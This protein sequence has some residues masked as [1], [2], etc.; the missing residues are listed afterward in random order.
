MTRTMRILTF[1]MLAIVVGTGHAWAA[2]D[3]PSNIKKGTVSNG[4]IE[5]YADEACTMSFDTD[6]AVGATVYVKAT[7]APGYTAIG[8]TFT[9]TKGIGTNLIQ[10]PRRIGI[11]SD[12]AVSAVTGKPD[13]YSFT[14]PED[15]NFTVTVSATFATPAQQLVSYVDG[16]YETK[17]INA[18]VLDETMHVLPAGFYIVPEGV[19][20]LDNQ[21]NISGNVNL[22]LADGCQM[23]ATTISGSESQLTIYAQTG[24]QTGQ[25]VAAAYDCGVAFGQ[26]FVVYN[27]ATGTAASAIVSGSNSDANA[28][29]T[30]DGIAGK[31]LRPLDGNY[32][33]INAAD[34]TFSGTTSTT[35]PFTITTGEGETATTTHY[36]IYKE[37]N[38]ATLSYTG[39]GIVQVTGLPEGYAAVENQPMQR[40]FPMPATDVEL[41]ATA[42]TDLTATSVTYDGT[43]RTPEIKQG[44]NVFDAANYTIAYKLGNDDVTAD[45]V[46]DANTYTCTLTGVGQYVGTT[47]VPL[48]IDKANYHE[49]ED[50]QNITKY[51]PQDKAGSYTMAL[52]ALPDGAAYS[53]TKTDASGVINTYSYD[54]QNNTLTYTTNSGKTGGTTATI[55]V[56][57]AGAPN[58]NDYS[59]T[60]N[61][62]VSE[63]TTAYEWPKQTSIWLDADNELVWAEGGNTLDTSLLT[64]KKNG[65]AVTNYTAKVGETVLGSG[66]NTLTL[67]PGAY[68]INIIGD[69]G[70][71]DDWVDFKV[72]KLIEDDKVFNVNVKDCT[73]ELDGGDAVDTPPTN[74]ATL[75][76]NG[77]ELEYSTDT[78]LDEFLNAHSGLKLWFENNDDM[79]DSNPVNRVFTLNSLADGEVCNV[80]GRRES[81]E[82]NGLGSIEAIGGNDQL[83]FLPGN[84]SFKQLTDD[85][86]EP[87]S[88]SS[89]GGYIYYLSNNRPNLHY[90]ETEENGETKWALY[91][92]DEKVPENQYF[93]DGSE[94]GSNVYYGNGNAYTTYN[95]GSTGEFISFHPINFVINSSPVD[96]NPD[97]VTL[98]PDHDYA[99][100]MYI[101]GAPRYFSTWNDHYILV[102][103]DF[104]FFNNLIYTGDVVPEVVDGNKIKIDNIIRSADESSSYPTPVV[105]LK[106]ATIAD[107]VPEARK[108]P[109]A[110]ARYKVDDYNYQIASCDFIIF[111]NNSN[112]VI[113]NELSAY[114]VDEDITFTVKLYGPKKGG[115]NVFLN[116][117]WMQRLEGTGTHEVTLP[118]QYEGSYRIDVYGDC[119]KY[120]TSFNTTTSINVFKLDPLLTLTGKQ[121][122]AGEEFETGANIEYHPENPIVVNAIT[123]Y[124]VSNTNWKWTISDQNVITQ[125]HIV[126]E[127]GNDALNSEDIYL[128]TV[129]L[130]E[131]TLSAR[132]SGN[133]SYNRVTKTMTFTVVPMQVATPIIEL[134]DQ[135][136]IYYDGTAKE[137]AVKVYYAEGKEIP[138][139]QYDVTY[140]NNTDA[141]SKAKIIVKSKTGALFTFGN[142]EMEFE[143]QKA[144]VT[145]TELPI[146]SAI[147][148]GQ[149][150][151]TSTLTGGTVKAG[152]LDVEG[153][154]AW[155]D[156]TVVPTTTDSNVTEYEV[157][158]TPKNSANFEDGECKVKLEIV[159][160]ATL[161]AANST[162]LWA[163]FC[164]T[165]ERT[166]PENCTAYTISSISGST[167]TLSDALTS[168][169]AYTPVLIQRSSNV[170]VPVT[171]IYKAT[172][173]APASGYDAQTGLAWT[174]GTAFTF[175]GH[176]LSSDVSA[177]DFKDYY[178]EG[179]TYLL[180]D[181]KFILADENGGLGA[182]KCLLVL[183]GTNNAPVLSIGETT[184]LVSIDNGQLTIDNDVWYTLDGRKLNGK[185]TKKGLYIHNGRKVVI[186]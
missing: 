48:T 158:F 98:D 12:I 151:A 64:V 183:N 111:P 102:G 119:D 68:R 14:M 17:E 137:P 178:N 109:H 138:A 82:F 27:A 126:N 55:T 62:V 181:G 86:G 58:Y 75:L 157:T 23:S 40:T 28:T 161:F 45:D 107:L 143:I 100:Y 19:L 74:H 184:N 69:D 18:Y 31:T 113:M 120:V 60:L 136:T 105:W 42:V 88:A 176:C 63:Y 54:A 13:I 92:G 15:V 70:K 34:F 152:E 90:V 170:T 142:T 10:A 145:V 177:D 173:A 33:S 127:S 93:L 80:F 53:F 147:A 133:D 118:G 166:L 179:Q 76:C 149:T 89:K 185:P 72:I 67:E 38:T 150:L 115:A 26:R 128:N 116:G 29:F 16:S 57:A 108:W 182:H 171:A 114:K 154:F 101:C 144:I 146:A 123:G 73:W 51:V 121:N 47:T 160:P 135:S 9:A 168:I 163:T 83:V 59:F 153:T 8:V 6:V 4:S 39:S 159:P 134:V 94:V 84:M 79:P 7:A 50:I 169:P 66:E 104:V 3:G 25:M 110:N 11:A 37:N 35:S 148:V 22:I 124:Y 49:P 78:D 155:K 141:S 106:N 156:N 95:A 174:P 103:K 87:V 44:D 5:F 132:F 129:G 56:E 96:W 41:T 1:L 65:A 117:E 30:L 99:F 21:L 112:A 140:E 46:K 24:G 122:T 81:W 167:V 175:Y 77:Q 43:A 186:K 61:V 97:G 180:F 52:P 32:V 2:T 71:L 139:D 130:G 20:A 172:G 165:Y 131:V 85:D 162:N 91:N 36:Y 125:D 164:D